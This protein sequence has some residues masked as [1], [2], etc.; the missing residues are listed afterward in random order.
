MLYYANM[1]EQFTSKNFP[2]SRITFSTGQKINIE[3][4]EGVPT[5]FEIIN[6][7]DSGHAA[8]TLGLDYDIKNPVQILILNKEMKGNL[9]AYHPDLNVILANN[10]TP[11]QVMHHEIIH[12]L[13]MSKLIPN[14]LEKFYEKVL[15]MFP[16]TSNL[17][18]N[19]R[20]NI[21]EFIAD[22]YSKAGFIQTLKDKDMHEEF[23]SLTKYI[24]E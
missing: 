4:N 2:E 15:D 8:A 10:D 18:P 11:P 6:V 3:N 9:A 17:N 16:D 20:N 22:G 12:S 23:K 1:H 5:E 7:L 14:D 24:F 13:E 19:F 21:H